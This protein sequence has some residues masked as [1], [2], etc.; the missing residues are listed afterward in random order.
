MDIR[1]T[2]LEMTHRLYD[3]HGCD[4]KAAGMTLEDYYE[5]NHP[6]EN[7]VLDAAVDLYNIATKSDIDVDD[8]MS[9]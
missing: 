3:Y 9:W 1:K 6:A 2:I 5:S 4:G 7:G 8:M